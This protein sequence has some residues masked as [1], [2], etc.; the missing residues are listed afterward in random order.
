MPTAVEYF[1]NIDGIKGESTDSKHKDEI[2]L[3]SF[4][5]GAAQ[6][7]GGGGGGGGAAGKVQ[8][9]DLHITKDVDKSSPI[10]FQRC[11]TG[12]HIK[13][14]TLIARKAGERQHEFLI[15]KMNDILVTSYQ[16][17][18][19]GRDTLP[20]EQMSLNFAKFE[21]SYI[22]QKADGTPDA[23]LHFKYDIKGNKEG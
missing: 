13:E 10:L 16:P 5:W 21:Y 18:G 11:A 12:T 17:G 14:G 3:M 8:F 22:P 6:L 9:Q 1:L 23:G 7:G 2:D 4:S 20:T 19:S 15:I